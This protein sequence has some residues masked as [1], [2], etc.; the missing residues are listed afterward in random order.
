MKKKK[1]KKKKRVSKAT[2]EANF[3]LMMLTNQIQNN[4]R[5]FLALRG[6]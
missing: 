6:W 3:Q 5:T 4:T 1:P 2:Q